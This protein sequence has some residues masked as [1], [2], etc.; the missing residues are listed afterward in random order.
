MIEMLNKIL[1]KMNLSENQKKYILEHHSDKILSKIES[2]WGTIENASG[3]GFN[4]PHALSTA[5]DSVYTAWVKAH[6]PLEFYEVSLDFSS[7]DKDTQKV[8][9]LKNEALKYKNIKV[10]PMTYGQN[11]TKFTANIENNEIWQSLMGVKGINQN[12]AD[13]VYEISSE[14]PDIKSF[15]DLYI[16]MKQAGLSK[17]H[18]E[19]LIKIKYFDNIEKNKKNMLWLASNYDSYSKKQINKD[20]IDKI[21]E[22]LNIGKTMSIVEFYQKLKELAF[23]ETEKL[24]KFE[25]NVFLKFIYSLVDINAY[26][27]LEELF[28]QCQLLGTTI[29]DIENDFML[30]KA[31]KYNPSTNKI[32]F[33]HIKTG[34]EQWLK[35]NCDTHIKENDYI[36]I[37]KVTSKK[38]KG[39]EYFTIENFD[40]LSEKY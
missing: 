25:D 17:T 2:I 13:K 18:I 27:K 7:K 3:Y 31:V 36:F 5:G 1:N 32:V 33:K 21:Y 16:I 37:H 30:G 15:C 20:N 29:D 9:L 38:W 4:A 8:G 19:I 12:I 24:F 28:W 39:R 14:Y 11:N 22:D 23:K 10:T 35:I 34:D 6:Y 26:D 40:N